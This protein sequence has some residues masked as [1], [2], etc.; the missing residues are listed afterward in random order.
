MAD[1]NG[2]GKCSACGENIT[3]VTVEQVLED[4]FTVSPLP[5]ALKSSKHRWQEGTLKETAICRIIWEYSDYEVK[6]KIIVKQP[7]TAQ[8][9]KHEQGN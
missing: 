3:P 8:N 9:Q 2:H 7:E 6:L 4:I 5:V 1:E